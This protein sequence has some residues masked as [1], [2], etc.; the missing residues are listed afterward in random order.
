MLASKTSSGTSIRGNELRDEFFGMHFFPRTAAAEKCQK[1][2]VLPDRSTQRFQSTRRSA[3]IEADAFGLTM[4]QFVASA[5]PEIWSSPVRK[6]SQSLPEAP[7][8]KSTAS[9]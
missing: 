4:R 7:L 5:W 8:R 2:N 9:T 1:T 6:I 3:P